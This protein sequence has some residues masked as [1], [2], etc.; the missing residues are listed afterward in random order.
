MSIATKEEA[1]LTKPETNTTDAAANDVVFDPSMITKF[2]AFPVARAVIGGNYGDEGK[3]KFVDEQAEE[4]KLEGF[5][6]LSAR[7]QGSG[8]AGHTVIVNGERLD[9]HYL[10]S[11]GLSADAMLLGPG[12]LI[13]PVRLLEEALKLPEEKRSII[14]VAERATIVSDVER[15]MDGWCEYQL[16]QQGKDAIGTTGSGVGP[17]SGNRGYRFHMTFKDALNCKD[18]NEFRS[19]YLKNP[20]LPDN[21]KEKMT[22]D[23]AKDLWEAILKLNIIDSVAFISQC[24]QEGNWA[25]L[26]EVSQAVGL[27]PLFGHSGHNVTSTPCTDIGGAT[28]AG[29][30]MQDFKEQPIIIVKAYT[31]KVGGGK[32]VTAMTSEE[33][34]IADLIDSIVGERGVTTGRR[35]VIGWFDAV[36][37]RY[38]IALTGGI[39]NVNCIDV[40]TQVAKVVDKIPICFAYRNIHTKEVTYD[41]PYNVADYEPIYGYVDVAG[42]SEKQIVKDYIEAIEMYTGQKILSYG[43]GPDRKDFRMREDAF[44]S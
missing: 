28:G 25:V 18:A 37:T 13:D 29:L 38:A 33:Q 3:G 22:N 36:L 20:L 5:N 39:L 12:M 9:F 15:S 27:D 7:G 21:V 26:L 35:R 23:Y 44:E 2:V 11:A 32:H 1:R 16:T 14:L 24:R 34:H 41:Y 40:I 19:A 17:G 42:K 6:V 43:V 10:T 8:N 4:W 31:T 30:T